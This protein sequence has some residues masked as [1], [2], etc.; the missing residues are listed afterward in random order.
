VVR[1]GFYKARIFTVAGRSLV[2]DSDGSGLAEH[3]RDA[4]SEEV[5][6]EQWEV[7][8]VSGEVGVDAVRE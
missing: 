7:C 1:C 2:C 8:G 6:E 5:A 4:L 3:E